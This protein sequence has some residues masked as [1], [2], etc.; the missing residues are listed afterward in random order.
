MSTLSRRFLGKLIV[1][2]PNSHPMPFNPAPVRAWAENATIPTYGV[3]QP[4][5]NPMFLEKRVYQG[6]S[7]V[8]YP[9]PV[10]DRV[11][12][13]KVDRAYTALSLENRFLKIMVLP[14]LG[15]RVQ[16]AAA[17]PAQHLRARGLASGRQWRRQP[18]HSV[19]RDRAHVLH[20]GH[21]CLYALP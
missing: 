2:L 13:E 9:Y 3:G 6:S 21:A 16:L 20:P 14:E 17:P 10:V 19:L 15:G 7:G 18:D 8:V 12:D 5:K 1:S 4:D 11:C